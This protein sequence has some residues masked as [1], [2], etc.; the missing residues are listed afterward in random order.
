M[1]NPHQ[2]NT[3]TRRPTVAITAHAVARWTE[4]FASH[5]GAVDDQILDAFWQ[6][7]K[8]RADEPVPTAKRLPNS[9]YYLHDGLNALF[10]VEPVSTDHL[11]IVTV[12]PGWR[13]A[14]P[15]SSR[16]V[17]TT[18]QYRNGWRQCME[19]GDIYTPTIYGNSDNRLCDEHSG[20][21]AKKRAFVEERR[22]VMSG[23]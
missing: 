17:L 8:L 15:Q 6:A 5:A 18:I 3:R 21:N 14:A 11:R 7:R 20:W 1:A 2:V 19:C 16:P 12:M 13:T 22:K 10:V 9:H 23:Y 4:R